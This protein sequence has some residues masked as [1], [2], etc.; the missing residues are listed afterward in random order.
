MAGAHFLESRAQKSWVQTRDAVIP[1]GGGGGALSWCNLLPRHP[2]L[3]LGIVRNAKTVKP[4]HGG[5]TTRAS[6]AK[7]GSGCASACVSVLI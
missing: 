6:G 1:G 3:A 4:Q 7:W 5:D 2:E